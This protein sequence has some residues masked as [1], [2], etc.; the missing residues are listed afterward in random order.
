MKIFFP[1]GAFYPSQIG[2]PCNTVYWHV[3]ELEKHGIRS[4]VITSMLGIKDINIH[5]NSTVISDKVDIYYQGSNLNLST[6][7]LIYNNIKSADIIHL[8][9]L[10]NIPATISLIL[11]ALFFPRKK[12]VCS[13]RGELNPSALKFSRWKKQ[14][15]LFLYRL[16]YKK[17]LFHT[18]SE[19]EDRDVKAFF[20]NCKTVEIP[21][22]MFPAEQVLNTNKKKQFLFIGRI[23]EIKSLH[24][25]IS[26][27]ALSKHFKNSDFILDI[28]GTHEERHEDYFQKLKKLIIDLDLETKI[29]FS[30]HLTGIKK[31]EK[32]AE[33]YFLVLPSETENFGNVVVES[34]NQ[35]TPVLASLGTPWK[36]LEEYRCGFHTNNS[37]E[38]LANFIDQIILLSDSE[39]IQM[40]D[41]ASTLVDDQFNI[42]TQIT[43]WIHIYQNL[44]TQYENTK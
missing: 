19:A 42:T 40:C 25:L 12:V 22:L 15:T 5:S 10:F 39:Y 18:T 41:N 23:H 16:L 32:Y 7:N 13:I 8:N 2:G 24:K 11:Y 30:G 34:L 38:N 28:T 43:R 36:I 33:S 27:L 14:P 4:T 9:G 20:T 35:K 44:L 26:A 6:I 31:E 3:K 1:I 37:P 21:N 29:K 17:I